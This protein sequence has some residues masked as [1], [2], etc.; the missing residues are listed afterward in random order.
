MTVAAVDDLEIARQQLIAAS[1]DGGTLAVC[2][3]HN[4]T[5]QLILGSGGF[6]I[7]RK[8]SFAGQPAA[9]K[10]RG[11]GGTANLLR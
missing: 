7:V 10:A 1:M 11:C 2:A 6:G 4:V 8:C 9:A 5:L 3:E